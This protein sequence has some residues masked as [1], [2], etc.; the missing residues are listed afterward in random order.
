MKNETMSNEEQTLQRIEVLL[1]L[2]AKNLLSDKIE[3][4]V[5]DRQR[6]IVYENTG[7]HSQP[8]LVKKTGL[9]AG[10]ISNLWQKWET[11]GLLAKDG[12]RYRRIL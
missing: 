4:I 6:R 11:M 5:K 3:E 8:E 2:I 7:I 1:K 10:T 12:N 9:S